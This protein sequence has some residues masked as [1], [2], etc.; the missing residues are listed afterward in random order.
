LRIH[1]KGFGTNG[2]RLASHKERKKVLEMRVREKNETKTLEIINFHYS[3]DF[4]P[5]KTKEKNIIIKKCK[6]HS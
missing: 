2:I 3:N 5:K 4:T 6:K 1:A